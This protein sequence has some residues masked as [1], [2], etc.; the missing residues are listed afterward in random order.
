MVAPATVET[1]AA[2]AYASTKKKM[3]DHHHQ[4][5]L[6][7]VESVINSLNNRYRDEADQQQARKTFNNY[8]NAR[9]LLSNYGMVMRSLAAANAATSSKS[10]RRSRRENDDDLDSE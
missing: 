8:V 5:H 7:P 6:L 1:L 4:N 2:T 10:F 9:K 3:I